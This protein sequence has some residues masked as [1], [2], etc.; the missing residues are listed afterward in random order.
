MHI[1]NNV[2]HAYISVLLIT[3]ALL[4]FAVMVDNLKDIDWLQ[5]PIADIDLNN[6]RYGPDYSFYCAILGGAL[7][8]TSAIMTGVQWGWLGCRT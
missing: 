5:R 4:L 2:F 8:F 7:S 6:L 1:E 3:A